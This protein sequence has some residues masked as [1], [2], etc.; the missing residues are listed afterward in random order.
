MFSL[1][2]VNKAQLEAAV[3][4]AKASKPLIKEIEF[5]RY[6]VRASDG[7]GRYSVEYKKLDGQIYASC[8]CKGGV[9]GACYHVASTLGH[10]KMRVQERAE[11]K[12]A[13]EAAPTCDKCH[14]RPADSGGWCTDCLLEC[15]S[16]LYG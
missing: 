4:R 11:A 6:E 12:R 3:E 8:N 15:E 10:F 5:G 1:S 2:T 16:E 14:D 9:K 7:Q 13:A